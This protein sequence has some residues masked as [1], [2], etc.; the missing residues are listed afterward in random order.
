MLAEAKKKV[1][2]PLKQEDSILSFEEESIGL[3]NEAENMT[4]SDSYSLPD[5]ALVLEPV[6][7]L[8]TNVGTRIRNRVN[9]ALS[10]DPPEWARDIL[11]HSISKEVYKGNASGPTKVT[12]CYL[13]H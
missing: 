5:W 10:K 7:K 3:S 12:W 2:G 4:L 13:F 8:P 9:D 6:R 1:L 11:L